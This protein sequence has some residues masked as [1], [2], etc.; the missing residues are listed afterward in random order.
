MCV[1]GD[2]YGSWHSHCF[3]SCIAV[4]WRGRLYD[5][6]RTQA[7]GV[8]DRRTTNVDPGRQQTDRQAPKK[9]TMS[10]VMIENSQGM[11]GIG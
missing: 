8:S 5:V 3:G 2:H 11:A 4:F 1:K 9:K 10:C 6:E 7:A